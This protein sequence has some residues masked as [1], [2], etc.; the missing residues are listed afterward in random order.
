MHSLHTCGH[1]IRK[2]T[3]IQSPHLINI[4]FSSVSASH[5]YHMPDS[6]PKGFWGY[7]TCLS[8]CTSRDFKKFMESGIKHMRSFGAKF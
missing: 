7:G 8:L 2:N 1:T 4:D 6:M 3:S 5:I